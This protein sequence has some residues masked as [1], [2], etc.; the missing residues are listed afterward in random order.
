MFS[1]DPNEDP[2]TGLER[3][4]S[5]SNMLTLQ[6][7]RVQR[8]QAAGEEAAPSLRRPHGKE[9][10]SEK[11]ESLDYEIMENELYRAAELGKEHQVCVASGCLNILV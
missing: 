7:R 2:V 8:R 6:R 4:S 1:L 3:V 5:L 9:T 11:F 10:L